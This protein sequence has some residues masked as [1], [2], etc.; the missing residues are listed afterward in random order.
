MGW[1]YTGGGK[2]EAALPFL[3]LLKILFSD[4]DKRFSQV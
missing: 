1:T 4:F 3:P 2:N